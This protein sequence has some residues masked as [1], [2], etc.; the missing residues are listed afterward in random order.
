MH[1]TITCNVSKVALKILF[2]FSSP[3]F[4]NS[5]RDGGGGGESV[6]KSGVCQTCDCFI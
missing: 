3:R 4:E 6:A 1:S 5:A 2:S